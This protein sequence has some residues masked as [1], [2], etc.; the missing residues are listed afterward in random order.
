MSRNPDSI[1]PDGRYEI[2]DSFGERVERTNDWDYAV[3]RAND[4]DGW[5]EDITKSPD[6][7]T[8]YDSA[9]R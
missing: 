5:V 3:E 1:D 9:D 6:K 4:N 2:V 8:V 7:Q